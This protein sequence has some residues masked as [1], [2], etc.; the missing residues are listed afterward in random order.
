MGGV[1][2]SRALPQRLIITLDG[3]SYRDMKALQEGVTDT[4]GWGTVVHRRAFTADEGY[5]PVSRMISTFPS[6]SDVAWTDIF[7]DR[8]QPGYQRTYFSVAANSEVFVNGLTSTIEHE[9]QMNWQADGNFARSMGYIYSVHTF[10]YE[11]RKLT[12]EFWNTGD[13]NPDFYIYIRSSDDAQHMDRDILS[14]LTSMDDD[15]QTLRARYKAKEGRDLQI[16][17]ISDHGHNHAGRGERVQIGSYLEKAGYHLTQSITGPKDVVLPM[18][19][20]EDW[21]EIHNA[22]SESATLAEKLVHLKGADVIAARLSDDTNCFLVLNSKGERAVIRWNPVQNTYQY[23]AKKGDPLGYLPVAEKLAQ[24]KRLDEDGFAT[25]DDWMNETM[26]N[27]YPLALQRIVRG[28]TCVVLNPATILVSLDNHYVNAGRL[29][30]DASLLESC[31]STHGALDDINSVGIILSNFMPTH[32]TSSERVGGLFDNFPGLR[33]YRGEENG[34]EWVSRQEQA[35]TRIP[36]DPFD[37]NYES[38][39]DDGVFLRVWSPE[40]AQPGNSLSLEATIEKIS[41]LP[42]PP[43]GGQGLKPTIEHEAHVTFNKPVSFPTN[44]L[45]ERVYACPPNLGLEP[46]ANYEISGWVEGAGKNAGR[47]EFDFHTDGNGRPAAY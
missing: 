30:N 29:V 35:A 16:L 24:K 9:R 44:C 45:Y 10:R 28:L 11:M 4:N 14:L 27:H 38:L 13:T 25:A 33:A 17:I 46:Q 42:D 20:I 31:G 5:F 21:I 39:P 12:Q 43:P 3:I 22:P 18:S 7:G 15:L 26:T 32:D 41:G 19:G 36:R 37:W 2:T 1:L 23:S 34:A 8:P 40:L 47:F 6:T